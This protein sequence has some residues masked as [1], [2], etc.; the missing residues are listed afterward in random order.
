K[1]HAAIR[2]PNRKTESDVNSSGWIA[3]SSRIL[4]H[5]CAEIRADGLVRRYHAARPDR[6]HGKS[7]VP[8]RV[9]RDAMRF[10][11][12]P[13]SPAQTI[14][15]INGLRA[16]LA[17]DSLV[18][19]VLWS[20]SAVLTCWIISLLDWWPDRPL[21]GGGFRSIWLWFLVLCL[22]VI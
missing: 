10:D 3:G 20:G 19:L 6:L 8:D 9:P 7:I 15:P 13:K 17:L 1:K 11:M 22:A 14:D 5:H 16:F 18:R 21:V 2:V 12:P 4:T